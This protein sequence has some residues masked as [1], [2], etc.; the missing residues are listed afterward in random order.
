MNQNQKNIPT[1]GSVVEMICM[2][3]DPRPILPGTKGIVTH[4]DDIGQIHVAWQ[5]KRMLAIIPDLDE[6]KVVS[7]AEPF[8]LYA[9]VRFNR[10]IVPADDYISPRGYE[11]LMNGAKRQFDFIH[12]E[13][14]VDEK[15]RNLLHFMQKYPDYTTF[16]D[17]GY[18]HTED[19]RNISE[20]YEFHIDT[21]T[22]SGRESLIPEELVSAS[23]ETETGE[24]AVP[25]E[26]CKSVFMGGGEE[27]A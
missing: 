2:K 24:Y 9:T 20:I 25:K 8:R 22:N 13:G 3:E 10:P 17:M 5:D 7:E 27:N 6:F 19:L 1:I 23:F 14:F 15:D 21:D 11:M 18:I 26:L 4:I 16:P 12:F